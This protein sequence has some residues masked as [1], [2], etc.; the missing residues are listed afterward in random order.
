MRRSTLSRG[1]ILLG[2]FFLLLTPAEAAGR[3]S[4]SGLARVL[5]KNLDVALGRLEGLRGQ[6]SLSYGRQGAHRTN[7]Q[8][9][10]SFRKPFDLLL[11]DRKSDMRVLLGPRECWLHRP[12]PMEAIRVETPL[13]TRDSLL[14]RM[15]SWIDWKSWLVGLVW[16]DAIRLCQVDVAAIRDEHAPWTV[17]FRLRRGSFWSGIF[18]LGCVELR[19]RPGDRF[20]T[21]LRLLADGDGGGKEICSLV[22]SR[23][24]VNPAFET[25]TFEARFPVKTRILDGTK[26]LEDMLRS[27]A[28]RLFFAAVDRIGWWVLSRGFGGGDE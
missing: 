3:S 26:A 16:E 24:E 7:R 27:E 17:D 19:L 15:L 23:I 12:G 5:L 10:F 13:G 21:R 1:L 14:A 22:I 28:T 11:Q 4:G 9:Q 6:L 20:P 8:M 2:S 25:G 18:G